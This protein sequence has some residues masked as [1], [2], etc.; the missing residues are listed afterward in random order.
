MMTHIEAFEAV[1]RNHGYNYRTLSMREGQPENYIFRIIHND[2]SKL[3][4][5]AYSEKLGLMGAVLVAVNPGAE[6]SLADILSRESEKHGTRLE[7]YR[8]LLAIGG[9]ELCVKDGEDLYYL[10]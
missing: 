3:T 2:P 5:K 8:L 9:W 10:T 4:A 7:T 1:L 6:H